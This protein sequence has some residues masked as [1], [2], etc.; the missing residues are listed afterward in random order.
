MTH[1]SAGPA[2]GVGTRADSL[3]YAAY[4]GGIPAARGMR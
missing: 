2:S 1:L 4:A 3:V